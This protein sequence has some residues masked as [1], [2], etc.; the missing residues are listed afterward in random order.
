[1]PT[2]VDVDAVRSLLERDWSALDDLCS[3]LTEQQWSSATCLPG[4]SVQDV[5]AHVVGTELMLEGVPAPQAD[6]SHLTH[7]RNDLARMGEVWVE[8][9]RPMSGAEVLA[10]FREVVGR[11]RGALAG[12]DQAAMDEPSW[13]PVGKDETYGRFM[14]IRHYDTYLHEH[15]IRDAL[16]VDDRPDVA[17]IEMAL[18][19]VEPA[20]GYVVG[21]KAALPERSVVRIDLTGPVLR[22]YLLGVVDG[23]A[24]ELDPAD[25]E[26]DATL[27]MGD[28]LFLRLTGGRTEPGPHLGLGL[29]IS[30]DQAM[31]L[32]LA[33]HMAMTI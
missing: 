6:V 9:M 27:A 19:E 16:G 29:E 8:D 22:S 15:D 2:S 1:M 23:R 28:L 26:P 7:L 18:T 10:R 21:R 25:H 30:G 13:T 17:S 14:R 5:L 24:T 31:G 3:P 20:L 32:H 11:R 33:S 12:M 4:W